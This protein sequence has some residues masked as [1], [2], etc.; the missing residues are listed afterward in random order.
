MNKLLPNQLSNKY[1]MIQTT[2]NSTTTT[3]KSLSHHVGTSDNSI[4]VHK[5]GKIPF[6]TCLTEAF[7]NKNETDFA[8]NLCTSSSG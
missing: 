7:L 6:I 4:N 8:I 2:D 1:T 5:L 3:N